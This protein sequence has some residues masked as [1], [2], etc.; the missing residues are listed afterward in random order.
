[1]VEKRDFGRKRELA[2]ASGQ[3]I[4]GLRGVPSVKRTFAW[5]VRCHGHKF[6]GA[7]YVAAVKSEDFAQKLAT[8]PR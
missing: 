2:H 4:T 3:L 5:R 6:T 7:A 8:I 1:M